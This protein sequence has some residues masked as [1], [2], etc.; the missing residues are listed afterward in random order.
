MA[1]VASS[2]ERLRKVDPE[3]I[4]VFAAM[5]LLALALVSLPSAHLMVN[6]NPADTTCYLLVLA[7]TLPIAIRRRFPIPAVLIVLVAMTAYQVYDYPSVNVDAFGPVLVLYTLV[8]SRPR[9]QSIAATIA[10]V[11]GLIVAQAFHDGEVNGADYLNL[12]VMV[13]LI[14]TVS[15]LMRSRR[16]QADELATRNRELDEARHE[17]AHQAV[18]EERVR[19]A[20]ELHDVVAHSMSVIAVQSGM[21]RHVIATQPEEAARALANI[22]ETS[23]SALNEMRRIL[24]VLRSEDEPAGSL[25]PAPTL[26]DLDH[27]ARQL[28]DAGLPVTIDVVGDRADVPAGVDLSAYR[29]VQEALTNVMKHAGDASAEVH[30]EYGNDAVVVEILDDGR[31]AAAAHD[32]AVPGSSNGLLGMRERVAVYGGE[33]TA[34]PRR[35]GGFRV[36]ARLPLN[37]TNGSRP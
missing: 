14:W 32:A 33:I 19:I 26:L 20:R 30:V 5:G 23:R 22:E 37:G 6:Q 9:W 4:D 17:L 24:S 1:T 3:A 21:G 18:A 27:L 25:A 36:H 35:G 11:A 29:I 7:L 34:G 16:A 10:L 15:E 28:D 2:I 12:G 31:G 8:Q 13:I